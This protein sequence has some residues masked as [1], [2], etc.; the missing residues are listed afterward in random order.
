MSA[1]VS[2][3]QGKLNGSVFTKGQRTLCLR[4]NPVKPQSASSTQITTRSIFL[5]AKTAWNALTDLQ[6]SQWESLA[7]SIEM[8]DF[9]GDAYTVSGR[10]LYLRSY[11]NQVR[12]G[13][14]ASNLQ[15][16]KIFGHMRTI[17]SGFA[18][19]SGNVMTALRILTNPDGSPNPFRTVLYA[20]PV[21]SPSIGYTKRHFR[22]VGP[23]TLR[24]GA[25]LTLETI[26]T[27]RFGNT[28]KKGVVHVLI[29]V[30]SNTSGLYGPPSSFTIPIP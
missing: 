24:V 21:M 10:M 9:F 8:T 6:K 22:F 28:A 19:R 20:T 26:W 14:A 4:N 13:F 25:Y 16:L 30:K 27:Q 1:L 18:T 29:V 7:G 3:V 15:P 17:L 5:Q 11:S 12:S 2:E 23:I